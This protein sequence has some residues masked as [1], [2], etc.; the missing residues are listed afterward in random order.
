ML[1]KT[2]GI[3]FNYLNYR[4][5]SVISR[6]YTEDFGLQSFLMNGVRKSSR[7]AGPRTALF[8]PLTIVNLVIY[9]RPGAD[10]HRISEVR[11]LQPYTSIPYDF[12]KSGIALFLAEVLSKS[13]RE[14]TP[15]PDLFRFL[16]ES[17]YQFDVMPDHYGNFHLQFLLGLS[18]FL[19]FMPSSAGDLY[20]QLF[21]TAGWR[22]IIDPAEE[23]ALNA[24]LQSRSYETHIPVSNTIRRS[25]LEH[26]MKFYDLHVA[27]FGEIRSLTVL[28]ETMR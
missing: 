15:N 28:Q 8:Q 9:Y 19:G 5:S 10:L 11:C 3:V 23:T 26:V 18:R 1:E 27:N 21:D 16:L 13:V 6:I 14:E 20:S 7:S 12:R 17:L 4:E 22:Q 2:Q 25:L 24:L